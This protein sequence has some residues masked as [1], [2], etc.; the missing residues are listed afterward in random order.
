MSWIRKGRKWKKKRRKEE[1]KVIDTK[2]VF[3]VARRDSRFHFERIIHVAI[4]REFFSLSALADSTHTSFSFFSQ[5]KVEGEP[6]G[7]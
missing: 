3:V 6:F 2:F 5:S 4:S 1:S 7:V